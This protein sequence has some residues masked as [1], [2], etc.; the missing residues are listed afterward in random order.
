MIPHIFN[1]LL[2]FQTYPVD[3][4][5]DI[6]K[7][8]HQIIVNSADHDMLRFLWLEDINDERTVVQYR[9]CWLVFGLTPIGSSHIEYG[10]PLSLG[11]EV[12]SGTTDNKAFGQVFVCG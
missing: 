9:F 3:I 12:H 1:I 2:R 10:H 4:I 8:F 11:S 5:A 7:A 6:E